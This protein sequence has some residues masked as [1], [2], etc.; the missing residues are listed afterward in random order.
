MPQNITKGIKALLAEANAMVDT[1]SVEDAKEKAQDESYVFVDLRDIR[2][3]Q[4]SGMIPG[5][6]SCTRGMLEFWIDPDSPYHKPIFNQD[7]TYV[8]YCASAWRSALSAR[9]AMEMGLSPVMH[10]EGGFTK[11]AEEGGAVV[12]RES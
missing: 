9:A 11:W 12:P 6:F 10:L 8:F 2:E 5:A 3:L 7:K 4:R 1:M